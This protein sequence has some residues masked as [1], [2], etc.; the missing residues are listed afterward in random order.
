MEIVTASMKPESNAPPDYGGVW[1]PRDVQYFFVLDRT[2]C[3]SRNS[4]P[5]CY[6]CATFSRINVPV[7]LVLNARCPYSL[8]RLRSRFHLSRVVGGPPRNAVGG[9]HT[10]N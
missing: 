10:C 6:A 8:S 7:L 2:K 3:I 9:K 5:E 1:S 4:C